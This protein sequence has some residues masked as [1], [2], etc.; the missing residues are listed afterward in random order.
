MTRVE[1]LEL[2]MM[3]TTAYPHTK[4]TVNTAKVYAAA[5]EDL[6]ADAVR[7]AVMRIIRTQ[8]F[9]P[10]VAEIRR[11]AED[12]P[13]TGH[14]AWGEVGA[15]VRRFG[16]YQQP[17]I[18]DPILAEAVRLAGWQALCDATNEQVTAAQFAKLYD[19][20]R[21]RLGFGEGLTDKRLGAP[22]NVIQMAGRIGREIP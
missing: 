6:E 11:E 12:R 9:F 21:T 5:L 13:M 7:R 19:A 4:A 15:L 18:A 2:V 3:L 1:A 14:E 10:S 16:R 22:S 8:Q 17:K 20:V